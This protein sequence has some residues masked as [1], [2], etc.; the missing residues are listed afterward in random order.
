MGEPD[1]NSDSDARVGSDSGARVDRSMITSPVQGRVLEVRVGP[2][3]R[4]AKG[5]V[6]AVI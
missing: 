2:G 5:M 3:D 4:V 1:A 6:L